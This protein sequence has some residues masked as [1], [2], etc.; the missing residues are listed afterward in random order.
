MLTPTPMAISR[1]VNSGVIAFTW[2]SD[3]RESAIGFSA[4]AAS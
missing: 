4:F 1:C 3:Q 2:Q